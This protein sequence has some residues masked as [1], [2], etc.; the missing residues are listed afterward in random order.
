M[1]SLCLY[2]CSYTSKPHS[3]SPK[4]AARPS[5]AEMCETDGQADTT[6]VLFSMICVE[7]LLAALYPGDISRGEDRFC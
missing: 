5:L 3:K 4:H 1:T 7:L 6:A 2:S